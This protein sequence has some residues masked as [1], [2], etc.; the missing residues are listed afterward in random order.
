MSVANHRF[1]QCVDWFN[2]RPVRER[3]L[4]LATGFSLILLIGWESAV[5]P[6]VARNDRATT[7]LAQTRQQLRDWKAQVDALTARAA[8]DPNAEMTTLLHSR[9]QRLDRLDEKLAE[10]TDQLIAPQAM[11]S[12]L[13]ELLSAQGELEL[14][15]LQLLAPVPVYSENEDEAAEPLLYA[16]DAEL[17]VAGGYPGLVAYLER[18]EAL[19][20]RL[21]WQ[22]LNYDVKT[23]PD[24][25]AIIRVRTLSLSRAWLGV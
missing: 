16:H 23:F 13:R 15:T 10:A 9:Q 22:Q 4:I 3:A 25:E 19:D 17:V 1:N 24:A 6:A 8:E 7:E 12:L 20:P 11:V 2:G 21:G 5:A 18:L 14:V